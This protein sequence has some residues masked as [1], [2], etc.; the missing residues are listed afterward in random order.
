MYEI[1][2]KLCKMRNVTPYKFCKE[3]EVNSSTISTWKKKNS[4]ASPE[5]AMKV[6][7]YF[8]ITYDYLMTGTTG[9]DICSPCPDCGMWYDA[10]DPEDVK[11]HQKNHAYWKKATEKFGKLYCNSVEN[12][13]IKG[14]NRTISHNT[15]LSLNERANAQLEVLRC[16]F[17][18]SVEGS[19]YDLRHVPFDTYI[20]MML[21]NETYRKNNLENDLYQTLLKQYGAKPGISSG[22]Y[23]HIPETKTIIPS[24]TRKD[25]R[26]IAKDL[27]NI[28][29]K[30]S[31]KEYGPAAYDGENLDP[32]A[33]ELFKDELKIALRRLKLINKEKYSPK[34]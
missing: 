24:I 26:D 29:D 14:E 13:R 25:E 21:R 31:L 18:R 4:L 2:E 30:L 16:L 9:N 27:N 11:S 1:F 23:Y 17:S 5:L 34:K 22:S 20:A 19:G 6:C 3:M 10:N 7:E 33:A 12:E 28:I 15:S 32:E 8:G